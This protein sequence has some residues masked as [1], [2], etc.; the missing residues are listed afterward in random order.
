MS[1]VSLSAYIIRAVA[2]L[3]I[4]SLGAAVF[5]KYMKKYN[6]INKGTHSAK[7]EILSSLRL[8]GRD[9]FFAVRCGPDVIAFVLSQGKAAFMGKWNYEEWIKSNEGE[10]KN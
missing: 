8:T 7:V 5:V 4:M 6:L 9:I 1:D 10:N 2:T 3:I